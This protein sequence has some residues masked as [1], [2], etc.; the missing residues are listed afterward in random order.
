M[1]EERNYQE[2]LVEACKAYSTDSFFQ[3]KQM[4]EMYACYR[5][6]CVR[7]QHACKQKLF[8][9]DAKILPSQAQSSYTLMFIS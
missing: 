9:E 1:K 4:T 3:A 6:L 2:N 7:M 8:S 5:I